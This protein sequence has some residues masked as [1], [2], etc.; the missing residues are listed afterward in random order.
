VGHET[1]FTI[2]D[3]VAD[4]RAATPTA[5]AE[6]VAPRLSE[7]VQSLADQSAQMS[8]GM[9]RRWEAAASR[10]TVVRRCEWFRDPLGKV[11]QRHQQV[12]EATGRARL[13][14]ARLLTRIRTGLHEAEVG[15]FRVRP[16][17]VLAL[18]RERV[19]R[20]EHRLRWAQ[21]RLNLLRERRLRAL[22][23]RLLAAS[24]AQGVA[25]GRL[26]LEHLAVRMARAEAGCLRALTQRCTALE[27]RLG[28]SSHEQVL[29]RGFSIT[30]RLRGGKIVRSAAEVREGDRVE[31]RTA[32]GSFHSRVVDSHQQE[33]FEE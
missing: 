19:A 20:A 32:E 31:T 28:A 22:D 33:L 25:R 15:L 23:G 21:G 7:V 6:L 17:A 2:A 26:M 5:A 9:L 24:P 30:R 16:E 11:R 3:F 4:L 14:M 10:L 12:D 27:E 18:R 13:A 29:R 8:R 1:D